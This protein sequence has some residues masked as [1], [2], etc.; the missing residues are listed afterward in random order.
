M[1]SNNM[2]KTYRKS[3]LTLIAA[4]SLLLATEPK[5]GAETLLLKSKEAK[6]VTEHVTCGIRFFGLSYVS[7]E[8]NDENNKNNISD[9]KRISVWDHGKLVTISVSDEEWQE[10]RVR[11]TKGCLPSKRLSSAKFTIE[12]K[13]QPKADA[14]YKS[15]NGTEV[16]LV[17]LLPFAN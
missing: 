3:S 16:K 4:M 10:T 15:I 6:K 17:S 1:T 7:F 13:A 2:L 8:N 9:W 12:I 11:T 5:A 14:S